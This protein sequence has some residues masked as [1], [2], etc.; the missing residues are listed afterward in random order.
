MLSV[1]LI[2]TN[3]ELPKLKTR[4][5]WYYRRIVYIK[6]WFQHRSLKSFL[7]SFK[8]HFSFPGIFRNTSLVLVASFLKKFCVMLEAW[9]RRG[10]VL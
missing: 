4:S 8:T 5:D 1:H 2:Y 9:K 3:K 6:E 7:V 10:R